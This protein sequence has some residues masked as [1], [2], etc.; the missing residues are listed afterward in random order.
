MQTALLCLCLLSTALSTPVL[1]PL[2]GR[3]AGNC[4]GQHRILL[5][6]CNA[7]HGFYVF[8]YI[9]LISTRRNQT[10]IEKEEANSQSAGSSRQPG[11][12]DARQGLM[13]GGPSPEG[14]DYGGTDAMENGT[15]LKTE[16]RSTPDINGDARGP[17]QGTITRPHS[18]VS[19][20]TS[21][22]ASAEGS[23]DLDLVVDNNGGV[24]ILPQGGQARGAVAGNRSVARNGDKEV[25]AP[26]GGP[27]EGAMTAGEE[28]APTTGG[29]GDEG[30]GEATVHSQGQEGTKHG[31]GMGSVS[32]SPVTEKMED[33]QVDSKGVDEYAY[34]PNS[35]SV[36]ITQGKVDSMTGG[37]SFTQISPDV[38]NEVN[39]FIG[40]ADIHIG[41]QE[42]TLAS[43][44]VSNKDDSIPTAGTSGPMPRMGISA[45][46]DG[47]GILVREQPEEP[48]TPSPG[49]RITSRPGDSITS[50]PGD[51]HVTGDDKDG[52]ITV[53]DEEGLVAPSS[54]R[55]TGS[56]V[57]VPMA[58]GGR[59]GDD[60]EARGEGQRAWG[61]LGHPAVSMPPPREDEEAATTAPAR[62]AII[63]LDTTVA[64][65]GVSKGDCTTTLRTASSH[66][67]SEN[68]VSR[69]G[70]SSE[71]GP[72]TL[73]PHSEGQPAAGA[74]VQPA[75][76][77]LKKPRR[78]QKVPS[79]RGKAGSHAPNRVQARA[80][81]HSG[82]AGGRLL[83]TGSEG[84]SHLQAGRAKGSVVAGEGW[85][86]RQGGEAGVVAG[87]RP[88]PWHGG[89]RLGATAPGEFT[90]LGR[91]REVDQVKHAD[92]LHV[93]EQAF[94]ALSRA[95]ADPH[96]L[97]TSL[98]SAE[99]SQSSEGS[100]SDNRQVGP[101][102][103]EW[104]NLEHPYSPWGWRAL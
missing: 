85:E 56:D 13:E 80:G 52:V 65:P 87:S 66:D 50:S 23:G 39:V 7:K 68:T 102:P 33:I 103:S 12:E 91:R 84:S 88:L 55:V 41:N 78:M 61:R 89:R 29:T 79:P 26:G 25:G 11:K 37:T 21:T 1:L 82:S 86:Q 8:K 71:A 31:K 35:G 47:G 9:Y 83:A 32:L 57:T 53:G 92:E 2:A 81:G 58:G 42:T 43:V 97:Y 59:K 54:W 104:G 45:A 27:V 95:G 98:G 64:S 15:S 6:G 73:Q 40:R 36:T 49:G 69:G 38:D 19:I 14:G 18:G 44:T 100:R 72:A 60:E 63:L 76:E 67:T 5:K 4:V 22:P 70:G 90:A 3:A 99:S 30:S 48:V 62:K 74:R 28:R 101:R 34:I 16:H 77:G 96:N 93:Q 10:Q 24:S 17:H 51:V 20:T 75:G 46:H 94:Y